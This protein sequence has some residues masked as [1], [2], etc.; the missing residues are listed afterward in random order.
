MWSVFSD[1]K[2]QISD[3]EEQIEGGTGSGFT[4]EVKTTLLALLRDVAFKGNNKS[5]ICLNI[6]RKDVE[7]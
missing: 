1:L 5:Q 3:I 7:N 2:S 4:E 6:I